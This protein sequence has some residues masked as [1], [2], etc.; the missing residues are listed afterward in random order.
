VGFDMRHLTAIVDMRH[1]LQWWT[2][3]RGITCNGKLGHETTPA[4]QAENASGRAAAKDVI[5]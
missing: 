3:T 2:L 5:P 1:H 4:M